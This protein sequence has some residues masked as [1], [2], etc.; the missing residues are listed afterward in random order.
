[1]CSFLE[2]VEIYIQKNKKHGKAWKGVTCKLF[3][4]TTGIVSGW[5]LVCLD[6]FLGDM[7]VIRTT[8]LKETETQTHRQRKT[9]RR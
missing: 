8:S 5:V 7:V 1:M 9:N 6:T 4:S 3:V 2:V